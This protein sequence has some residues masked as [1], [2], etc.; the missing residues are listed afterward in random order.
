MNK[1]KTITL[2][3]SGASGVRYGLRLLECL[4]LAEQTVYL[5]VSEAAK[6]VFK[7][8]EGIEIS[9][10]YFEQH[11]MDH[12]GKLFHFSD[13]E[14]TAPIASGSGT[15]DAMVI[16]PCSSST[17]A[18][19]AQG[20]SDNLLERSADVIL[21]ERKSLILVHRESPLSAIHLENMLKL[22]NMGAVIMP[23]SPGFYLEPQG[24][25]DLIDFIVARVLDHLTV[26]HD[27]LPRWGI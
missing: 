17:L 4:L 5:V 10:D 14:W 7:F 6:A 16:C 21:K 20:M 19:I 9:E 1:P 12:P 25:D 11:F 26:P 22:T 3:M 24:I 23:A 15:S 8:E 2:A 13:K 18:A 27:L